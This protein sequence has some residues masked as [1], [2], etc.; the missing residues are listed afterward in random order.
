M[1]ECIGF[2]VFTMLLVCFSATAEAQLLNRL[3]DRAVNAA[4]N[5]VEQKIGDEVERAAE[6][7]VENAWNSA[8]GYDPDDAGS[9]FTIPFSF[10]SNA[11][12][13][14]FYSFDIV[15]TMEIETTDSE[16]KSEEPLV[17]QMLFNENE[18][19]SGTKFSGAQMEEA[20]GEIFI[21]YDMKN[22]SMVMLM[23]SNDG[24]FSFAYDWKQAAKFAQEYAEM[25]QDAD[26]SDDYEET[27]HYEEF[28][29]WQDFEKLGTRTIAG[30]ESQGFLAQ[31]E[32]VRTE[33]W[34]SQD[35][36]FG[37]YN[38][39]R[40]NS[41]NKQLRGKVPEDYP[42]GML[43]ELIHEDLTTGEITTMK[44]TEIDDM[45]SVQYRMS[46]YPAM[47]FGRSR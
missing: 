37:I 40:T 1:K 19:Y 27:D 39:L 29:Y 25:D 12:T 8:F 5:R 10:N 47:S 45:A 23:E 38:M 20:E 30:I 28:D 21:I 36:D 2:T 41:H 32:N 31:D 42:I 11:A 44:V 4:E 24:N 3:K 22:E 14:D 35:Q 18:L 43:M 7:M 15:T 16:G 33:Y 34:V 46:D 26:Y 17:M 13:E 6:R 9:G